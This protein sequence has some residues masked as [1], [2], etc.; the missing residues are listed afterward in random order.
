M[1]RCLRDSCHD[2]RIMDCKRFIDCG[3]GNDYVYRGF[4]GN[5][6]IWNEWKEDGNSS[7]C[8][9][10]DGFNYGIYM[11]AVN[12]TTESSFITRYVYSSFWGL[13]VLNSFSLLVSYMKCY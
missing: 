5:L 9:S 4:E 13:Q 3:R 1:N 10:E 6:E 8:F 2:S 11:T 12:L 7:A